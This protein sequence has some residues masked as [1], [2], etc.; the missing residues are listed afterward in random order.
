MK[1]DE[2]QGWSKAVLLAVVAAAAISVAGRKGIEWITRVQI[3]QDMQNHPAVYVDELF[4]NGT[5][6]ALLDLLVKKGR[7]PSNSADLSFYKTKHEHIGEAQPIGVDGKCANKYLLPNMNK[8]LCV[9][10]G[11]IDIARTYAMTGGFNGL[12]ENLGTLFSRL[13]SFGI[14][15]FDIDTEEHR[16]IRNLF[17]SETFKRAAKDVC[18]KNKQYLDP[19]Q[20]N[21][22]VQ[23]AGQTVA[24]HIDGVY[25]WGA[26]R[27]GFPQWLLA[28]MKFSG[29]FRHL[30]VDQVQ[31]VGYV[32]D[33]DRS[34]VLKNPSNFGEFVYWDQEGQ[35]N[36]RMPPLPRSGNSVDGSKTMHT[37]TLHRPDVMP[38]FIDK[39]K[40]NRLEYNSGTEKWDLLSD[41][42]VINSYDTK[43][44]RIS[45]VYRARC[46]E[47]KEEAD[48]FSAHLEDDSQVL[49]LEHIL[50]QLIK[51]GEAHL[52]SRK[53]P[54]MEKRLDLAF[55]LLDTYVTYPFPD[56]SAT[57]FPFN[58]CALF[59]QP[60]FIC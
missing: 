11:R 60:N 34:P 55:W 19:F 51:H 29:L 31:V 5:Q 9:L 20:F 46:F 45:I 17:D 43:E 7:I 22:I 15:L 32:S 42:D 27:F 35:D 38:P 13:Q 33:W 50:A 1:S 40:K 30:F 12:K 44:L 52:T 16:V 48:R 49:D 58:F 26:T 18:P 53:A 56:E 3:P 25:F 28:V 41:E 57:K 24:T 8:T 14:Y 59:T 2:K 23:V 47:D 10:P 4:D 54:S 39:N 37:T 21:Y 6:R 36:K